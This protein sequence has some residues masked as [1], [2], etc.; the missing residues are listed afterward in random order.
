MAGRQKRAT[1]KDIA[2]DT[3]LSAAA[4]SYALRGLQVPEATQERVRASA[5]RLGYEADPIARALAG[6][7]TGTVGVLCR[8]LEDV[9]QQR[10]AAALGRGLLAQDRNALI[11]DAANDPVREATL[12]KRLVDQRADA[13]IALPV[14]PSSAHWADIARD[15][16]LVSVGDGL[17][18]VGTAAEVVFDNTAGVTDALTVLSA[19]GHR[20][21]AV[22]T[23]GSAA[24]PDRP[25]EQVVQ[26]VA[27]ELGLHARLV[28]TPHDLAG[29]TAVAR[30][31]L[32]EPDPPTAVFALADAM[33]YGVYA[34]ARELG[35]AIPD[36]VSV[37][38]YDDHPLSALL[39]P[40]LTTYLWPTDRIVE[41][42][43]E[44][45]GQAI[46]EGRRTRRRLFAPTPRPRGSVAAPRP[47]AGG[48]DDT[49]G[50]VATPIRG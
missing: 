5:E 13:I 32:T 21:V 29:A 14:D 18:G 22:L 3:G 43:V 11:V 2:N 33:A 23:P 44:R 47:G 24:T 46:D 19:A 40:P 16:P 4:V 17:P 36:D 37:L 10:L 12:A 7:R 27:P 6:G 45:V 50:S 1:I 20:E 8:S 34:A 28:T 41:V 26:Q 25:A 15:V 30:T 42:V 49:L 38:G 48:R 9:W 35:L 39:T 31:L